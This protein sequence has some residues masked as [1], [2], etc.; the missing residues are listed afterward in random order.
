MESGH[1]NYFRVK[2]FKR[3]RNLE[4]EDIG[5]FNL[6]LGDNNV[7]KTSL[8]EALM[9][10]ESYDSFIFALAK[11]L[12]KRNVGDQLT[13][14]VWGFFIN[15]NEWVGT[16]SAKIETHF[17]LEPN[18][19]SFHQYHLFFDKVTKKLFNNVEGYYEYEKFMSGKD[20]YENSYQI[21]NP[22]SFMWPEDYIEP[23]ISNLDRHDSNLTQQYS[24]LIQTVSKE[25]KSNF[26]ESLKTIDESIINIEIVQHNTEKALL[27]IESSKFDSRILLAMYGDGLIIFFRILLLIH[28]FKDKKLM[29]D[30]MDAGIYHSRMKD[31]W[32]VIL[33]S[34]KKN[35]V[36]LF[37]TTHNRECIQAYSEAL[38]ELGDEYQAKSR[39]IRLVEHD[40][41][42]DVVAF[43][44]SYGKMI[45]EL[46]TGNEV[47]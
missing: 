17:F 20:F 3:F 28:L 25:V 43:T 38:G 34:A 42:K 4:V 21:S 13:G 2:N 19:K 30:E 36:Q 23:F 46:A 18:S 26:I 29:L 10:D 33:E 31:Y 45:E 32:K 44:N 35:N 15:N 47:R 40:Q 7:G 11:R 5:Q 1:F 9:F 39:T 12:E 24:K 27:T 14:G 22:T 37:A 8:L 41:S 16:S 6:V